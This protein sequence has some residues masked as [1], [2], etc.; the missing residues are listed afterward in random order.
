MKEVIIA[1]QLTISFVLLNVWI[2]RYQQMKDEFKHY[3]L[4]N[5]LRIFTCV[6]K[7]SLAI[8]LILGIWDQSLTLLSVQLLMVLMA[9]ALLAHLRVKNPIVKALPALSLLA[10]SLFIKMSLPV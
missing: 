9:F 6:S 5:W 8:L 7:V 2:L 3:R 10:M 4:P 1:T